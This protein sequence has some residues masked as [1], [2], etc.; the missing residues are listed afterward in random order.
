MLDGTYRYLSILQ[1]GSSGGSSYFGYIGFNNGSTF[2]VNPHKSET[3]IFGCRLKCQRYFNT[4][5]KS[6][7]GNGNRICNGILF[8]YHPLMAKYYTWLIYFCFEK[9]AYFCSDCFIHFFRSE[10]S[11][12]ICGSLLQTA[13]HLIK[14][15]RS[16]TGEPILVELSGIL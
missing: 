12:D 7:P 2:K 9:T 8:Y 3:G 13:W 16:C 1:N 6:F 15:L 4:C 14:S 10:M 5:M 11:P